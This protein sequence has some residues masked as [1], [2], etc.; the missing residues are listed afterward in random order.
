MK[1]ENLGIV[2]EAK[3]NGQDAKNPVLQTHNLKTP[4]AGRQLQDTAKSA[5]IITTRDTKGKK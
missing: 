5:T 3:G 4:A 2:M 1:K